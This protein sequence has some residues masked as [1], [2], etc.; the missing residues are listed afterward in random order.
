M[1]QAYLQPVSYTHLSRKRK[2]EILERLQVLRPKGLVFMIPSEEQEQELAS[3]R[4]EAPE[5][6]KYYEKFGI[7]KIVEIDYDLSTMKR[8]LKT[9]HK[10]EI[11]LVPIDEI[12]NTIVLGKPYSE[13]EIIATLQMIYDKYNLV[14]DNNKPLKAKATYLNKYF[15]ISERITIPK[16][17]LKGY[18]P[19]EKKYSLE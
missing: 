17:R 3:L 14:D 13:S 18:I 15:R 2:I 11:Y 7:D 19:F 12:Y 16:S 10:A 5:L 6:C 1:E 9:K 4:Y 8:E